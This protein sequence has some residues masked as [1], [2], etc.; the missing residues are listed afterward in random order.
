MATSRN[1]KDRLKEAIDQL[2]YSWEGPRASPLALPDYEGVLLM[3][4]VTSHWNSVVSHSP[5]DLDGYSGKTCPE[6]SVVPE[7][8]TSDRFS[9]PWKT[10]G[11]VSRGECLTLSTS[12]SPNG[13]V[14]SSLSEILQEDVLNKYFLSPE[15]CAG[16]LNRAER[17]GRELPEPLK[18]V[19]TQCSLSTLAK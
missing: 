2:T 15:A 11:I 17:R 16:I 3:N 6:S 4:A 7:A 9:G 5:L 13:V 14:D 18:T 10:S 8:Q 12:E 1:W 19:L